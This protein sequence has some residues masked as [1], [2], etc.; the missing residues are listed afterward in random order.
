[1][2]ASDLFG[3]VT[4][5]ACYDAAQHRGGIDAAD[6]RVVRKDLAV[7]IDLVRLDVDEEIAGGTLWQLCRESAAQVAV[8]LAN[9]GEHREAEA[10]R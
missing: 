4:I 5:D 6:G 9:G 7:A 10:K 3:V 1:M 8:D 2:A